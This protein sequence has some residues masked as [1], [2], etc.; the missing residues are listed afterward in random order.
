L[1]EAIDAFQSVQF[2]ATV[3]AVRA[4][5]NEEDAVA[6]L[7]DYGRGRVNAVSAG[8]ALR[9]AAERFLD[10]VERNLQS[11]SEDQNSRTGVVANRLLELDKALASIVGDLAAMKGP[12]AA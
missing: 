3:A 4:L 7:P 12:H 8:T 10:A 6:S 9:V 5:A 2:D 11:F 1:Q